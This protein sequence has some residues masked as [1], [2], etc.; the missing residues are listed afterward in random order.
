M[1]WPVA[2]V[3]Y[4]DQLAAVADARLRRLDADSDFIEAI[5]AA[6]AAGHTYREIAGA[7]DLSFQRVAQ[8]VAEYRYPEPVT[9]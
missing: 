3:G 8:I 6:H 5:V 2:D 4:P 9:A 7:A 1:R